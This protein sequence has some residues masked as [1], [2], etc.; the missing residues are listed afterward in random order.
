[1]LIQSGTSN[2]HPQPSVVTAE[3]FSVFG[4]VSLYHLLNHMLLATLS[5]PSSCCLLEAFQEASCF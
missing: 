4:A 5:L 1:M 3:L 2:I